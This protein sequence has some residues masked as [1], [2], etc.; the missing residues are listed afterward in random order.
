MLLQSAYDLA[1]LAADIKWAVGRHQTMAGAEEAAHH[2][3]LRTQV[4]C[5]EP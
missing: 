1:N 2:P 4:R 5:K 3:R